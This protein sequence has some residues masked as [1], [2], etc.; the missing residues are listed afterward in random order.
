VSQV[1]LGYV[2]PNRQQVDYKAM[3]EIA[4]KT[5]YAPYGGTETVEC[6]RIVWYTGLEGRDRT[7]ESNDGRASKVVLGYH[8]DNLQTSELNNIKYTPNVAYVAG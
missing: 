3:F 6:N 7:S 1:R 8:L 2:T 5:E 4:P